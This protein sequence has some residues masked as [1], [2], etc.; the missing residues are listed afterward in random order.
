MKRH[1][2]HNQPFT[3]HES[4][5]EISILDVT[6][7]QCLRDA[8][9]TCETLEKISMLDPINE[10]SSKAMYE[11]LKENQSVHTLVWQD[12][13]SLDTINAWWLAKLIEETAGP[14]RL[15]LNSKTHVKM[16]EMIMKALNKNMSIMWLTIEKIG[17]KT[18]ASLK[19]LAVANSSI[20]KLVLSKNLMNPEQFGALCE[21]LKHNHSIKVLDISHNCAGDEGMRVLSEVLKKSMTLRTLNMTALNYTASGLQ[22][23]GEALKHNCTLKTLTLGEPNELDDGAQYISDA[24]K[25]NE[26]LTALKIHETFWVKGIST[27]SEALKFNRFL[28]E[29]EFSGTAFNNGCIKSVAEALKI[30][31][32]VEYLG[33]KTNAITQ[34]GAQAIIDLVQHN[35]SL[36]SLDLIYIELD[37]STANNLFLA[38]HNNVSLLSV[39][40]MM[41]EI[42]KDELYTKKAELAE[43]LERNVLLQY[44]RTLDM[45]VL[46]FNVARNPITFPKD[47]WRLI[48]CYYKT[49]GVP[50]FEPLLNDIFQ[51]PSIRRVP[52]I[53]KF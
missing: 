14:V 45:L 6:N 24:L 32:N 48:F 49:P 12:L 17:F 51:D 44:E 52:A 41:D 4:T 25:V 11:A 42:F 27:I 46:F 21:G 38:L 30:N 39:D 29:L 9:Q 5:N 43:I 19:D 20:V 8:I 7:W 26:S 10:E 2:N 36:T 15:D 28:T 16:H 50:T 47:I 22:Y 3:I 23:L 37:C 18:A 31:T 53:S 34:K 35:Q 1:T 33:F 13:S 40:I